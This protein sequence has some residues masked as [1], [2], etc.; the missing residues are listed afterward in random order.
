MYEVLRLFLSI[1]NV[2]VLVYVKVNNNGILPKCA[3]P[4][5][6]L[7]GYVT[8]YNEDASTIGTFSY[9]LKGFKE[10]P[11]DCYMRPFYMVADRIAYLHR[12]YCWGSEFH[13]EVHFRLVPGNTFTL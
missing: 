9:R 10:Q 6:K 11:T 5:N 8:S 12:K 13:H 3:F 2:F 7:S 4:M 1:I